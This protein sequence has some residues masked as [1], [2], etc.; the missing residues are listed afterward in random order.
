MSKA[1]EEEDIYAISPTPLPGL[2]IMG[3]HKGNFCLLCGD[4]M[5][6]VDRESEERTRYKGC[7][8]CRPTHKKRVADAAIVDMLEFK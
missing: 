2:P 5:R 4:Y 1:A 8:S 7:D 6:H 3:K